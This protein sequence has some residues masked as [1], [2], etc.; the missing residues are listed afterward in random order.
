LSITTTVN[1]EVRQEADTD[2]LIFALPEIVATVS[3]TVAL[4]PGDVI[5]TASPAGVGFVKAR[6]LS[7]GD[8]VEV[9]VGALP[10]L[11]NEVAAAPPDEKHS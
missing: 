6:F 4:H 11:R 7:P 5:L 2:E 3:K 9:T 8:V 1:G 10:P